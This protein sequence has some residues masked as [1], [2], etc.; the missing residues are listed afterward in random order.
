MRID[1]ITLFPAMFQGPFEESIIRIAR[2]RGRV[3]LRIHDLREFSRE[4]HRKVD[5]RRY[6]GGPGMVIMPDPVFRA[7]ESIT[8]RV[9][10]ADSGASR[11]TPEAGRR[12]AGRRNAVTDAP[13]LVLLTP[14]GRT[15][16]RDAA[17]RAA[18]ARH[19]VVLCGHY[20]GF[21]ERIHEAFP[22]VEVSIGDYVLT[23]GEI[24]A[25]VLVDSVVRLI[26][27]VVGD[28]ESVRRD[29]F[30]EGLLD[31][32][33]YTRPPVYRGRPVP[34]VLRS[35]DHAAIASWR[36][37]RAKARTQARR[38]TTSVGARAGSAKRPA[39]ERTE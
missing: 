9:A 2:Q 18:S 13:L 27:G 24:P 34:E 14:Q 7:I 17:W 31:H 4:P 5:D 38:P 35:G 26:P 33:H 6:G 16:S 30:E 10:D 15:W 39:R 11:E 36:E 32:P 22:F 3:D 8:G 25:M 21:D 37:Q 1:V 29:S 28:P 20:E 12:D 23:G 19:L